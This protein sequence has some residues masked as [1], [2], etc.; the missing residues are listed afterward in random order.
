MTRSFLLRKFFKKKQGGLANA[1][2][3]LIGYFSFFK[4]NHLILLFK[5]K[6]NTLI[7]QNSYYFYFFTYNNF[8]LLKKKH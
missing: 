6:L 7:L 8:I 5:G 3:L 1:N 4:K 2:S